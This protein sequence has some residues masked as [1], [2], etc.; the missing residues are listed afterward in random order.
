MPDLQSGCTLGYWHQGADEIMATLPK[1]TGANSGQR[2]SWEIPSWACVSKSV[3]CDIFPSVL[4]HCL[5]GDRKGIQPVKKLDVGLLV[6]MIDWRFA[7][8][9]APVVT[10][11]SIIL[12]LSKHQLNLGQ[13]YFAPRSTQPSIPPGSVNEYRLRMNVWVCR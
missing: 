7:R 10:T 2:Q 9:V 5:L 11:T 8:L 4:R 6:M 3:E 1:V 12:C 13:N